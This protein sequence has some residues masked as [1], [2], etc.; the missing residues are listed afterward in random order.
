M[1]I[2]ESS[3]AVRVHLASAGPS[4]VGWEAALVG[5]R[6][7]VGPALAARS[8]IDFQEQ[9]VAAACGERYRPRAPQGALRC[10]RCRSRGPFRR[11]GARRR[12]L[13]SR[14][15]RLELRLAMIG[16][17]CGHRFAPL[18]G[19]L[20][21][22]PGR[23]CAPEFALRALELGT[24]LPYARAQAALVREA[25]AAPS[26]RTLRRLVLAAAARCDLR[27][28]RRD[29]GPV[30]A[31]LVDGTRIRAGARKRARDDRGIDFNLA[32]ALT[33]RDA[34]HRRVRLELVGA[35]LG[36][37]WSALVPALRGASGAAIAV[38]DGDQNIVRALSRAVPAVPQQI[39]TFHLRHSLDHRLWQDHLALAARRALA[40]LV[41]NAVEFAR[42]ATD[43]NDAVAV[44]LAMAERHRWRHTAF[45]LRQV[46]PH[47]AT[48]LRLEPECEHTTSVLERVMREINRRVDPVGVRWSR[49]GALAILSLLLA[50][51]FDHP[52]WLAF[53]HHGEAVQA[54][55][56]L[57]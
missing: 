24:K 52:A 19:A 49:A 11:R 41:G 32:V 31:P 30:R 26:E 2:S 21:L 27:L 16:C 54:W 15:G 10:P 6:E 33:G 47:V 35:T 23:R 12:R 1:P 42:D 34:G 46:A 50:R 25:G 17:G 56:E 39:C 57:R 44:L 4:L 28:R 36:R 20:G 7:C 29:L 51:R 37:P 22:G 8:L 55:A 45:H 18:L 48:W 43:A 14:V 53:G 40:R 3:C 38:S 9:L 5:V 13:W